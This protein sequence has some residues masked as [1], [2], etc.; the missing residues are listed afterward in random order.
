MSQRTLFDWLCVVFLSQATAVVA[1]EAARPAQP[2]PKARETRGH[3]VSETSPME[4]ERDDSQI[5]RANGVALDPEDTNQNTRLQLEV[6]RAD[7]GLHIKRLLFANT[8]E[9]KAS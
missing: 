3:A 5:Q 9:L 8:R 2:K 1:E 7:I 6:V 4:R